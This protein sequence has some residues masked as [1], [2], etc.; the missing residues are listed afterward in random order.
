VIAQPARPAGTGTPALDTSPLLELEHVSKRFGG[1]AAVSDVSFTLSAG[2][3]LG[4]V[5]PNGAGK[6]T[7]INLITGHARPSGGRIKVAGH[8]VTGAPPWVIS[9]RQVARTFQIVKPFRGMTV[10][11][12]VAV[13]ALYGHDHDLAV[14]D[15]LATA[16]EMLELVGLMNRADAAPTELSVADA[17]RLELAKALATRPRLLLLDEVMAGLRYNEIEAS[18]ELIHRLRYSGI[19]FI[20][21]EHVMKAILSISD[22]LLVLH[23]GRVLMTGAPREVLSN[24]LVIEA[25][26]GHRYAARKTP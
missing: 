1:L 22:E 7:L 4:V 16:D 24:E 12:N 17:R 3:I 21:V 11:E 8:D 20:A 19:S 14:H 26:L 9:H 18:V 2:T 25:Y 5:G 15:A 10:R 6:S 23:Q 13:G